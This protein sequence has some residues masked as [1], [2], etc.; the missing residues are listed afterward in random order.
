MGDNERADLSD[1]ALNVVMAHLKPVAAREG[2][3]LIGDAQI[4]IGLSEPMRLRID[5]TS[6]K[7]G[8]LMLSSDVPRQFL[9][10]YDVLIDGT[11]LEKSIDIVTVRAVKNPH[12]VCFQ[13]RL[14]RT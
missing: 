4:M 13:R 11:L 9:L 2:N 7:A 6:A 5:I 14:H 8:R 10:F 3:S 1:A 12:R